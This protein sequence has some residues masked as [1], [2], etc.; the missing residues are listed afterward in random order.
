[1][2]KWGRTPDKKAGTPY[3]RPILPTPP[4]PAQQRRPEVNVARMAESSLSAL[5]RQQLVAL[6]TAV[7][8]GSVPHLQKCLDDVAWWSLPRLF[9]V[10][11]VVAQRYFVIL[12]ESGVIDVEN[13]TAMGAFISRLERAVPSETTLP[14]Q[15]LF[16]ALAAATALQAQGIAERVLA[17]LAAATYEMVV[18]AA[19]LLCVGGQDLPSVASIVG[20]TKFPD[21]Q[22]ERDRNN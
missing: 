17:D 11:Q 18:L 20:A 5:E 21:Q 19:A 9:A 1:M 4:K 12:R 22:L 7:R 13:A 16:N 15:R 10:S 14:T 8:S 3:N 2:N 6:I